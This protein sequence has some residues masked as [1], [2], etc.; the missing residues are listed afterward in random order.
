MIM[1]LSLPYSAGHISKAAMNSSAGVAAAGAV[2]SNAIV[3]KGYLTRQG[4]IVR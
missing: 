1:Q 4:E 2:K 3:H